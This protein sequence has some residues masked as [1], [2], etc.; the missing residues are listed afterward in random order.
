MNFFEKLQC[1]GQFIEVGNE[2]ARKTGTYA[3]EPFTF[4][5]VDHTLQPRLLFGVD[6]S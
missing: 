3:Q 2:P 6:G 4:E 5:G 1:F